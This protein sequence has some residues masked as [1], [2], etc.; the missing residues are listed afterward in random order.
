MI[1]AEE[2][3]GAMDLDGLDDALFDIILDVQ[4]S[5]ASATSTADEA[6]DLVL[7]AIRDAVK[8]INSRQAS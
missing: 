7:K 3:I 5:G 1:D 6:I 4:Y 2:I 8:D